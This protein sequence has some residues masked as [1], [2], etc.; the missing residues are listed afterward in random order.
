[1]ILVAG[2]LLIAFGVAELAGRSLTFIRLGS[3]IAEAEG[4]LATYSLGLVYGFGGFCSGPI[5]GSVLT[6]AAAD[7]NPL[8]GAGLLAVY[9]LGMT[10]PLFVLA[11]LWDSLRIGGQR[12]LRGWGFSLGPLAIH[13]TNLIAGTIFTL[14]GLSFILLQGTTS[15][16]SLY[17]SRGLTDISFEADRAVKDALSSRVDLALLAILVAGVAA[18][19]WYAW[20]RSPLSGPPRRPP[21]R[22]TG[23]ALSERDAGPP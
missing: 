10:V 12:W 20:R 8:R 21:R 6:V 5:L 18:M 15:L 16:S 7:A 3:G 4:L 17:E 2:V 1:M 13:S 11:A 22:V 9:A 14:L 19:A 23:K